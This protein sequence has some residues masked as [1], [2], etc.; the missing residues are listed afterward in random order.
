MPGMYAEVNLTLDRRNKVLAVPVIAVD[1]DSSDAQSAETGQV[2]VV[3]PNN[4]VE[5][6][7]VTLGIETANHVEIRSGSQRRRHASSSAAAPACSPA[8]KCSRRSPTMVADD[9]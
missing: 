3:T 5:K 6:R 7:K 8:R 4:R 9:R 1:V 2:M